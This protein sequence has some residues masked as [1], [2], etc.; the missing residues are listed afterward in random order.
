MPS[1][2]L[3]NLHIGHTN[4][5]NVIKATDQDKIF[6]GSNDCTIRSWN[7]TTGVCEH[8]F[9]FADPISDLAV[10]LTSN[11]IYSASWDKMIRIIDLEAK[12]VIKTFIAAKEAIKCMIVTENYIFV[13]GCDSIIRGFNVDSGE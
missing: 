7:A 13:S 9:K 1:G 12:K 3:F 2:E 10:S 4:R 5:I 6:S 11:F 8:V